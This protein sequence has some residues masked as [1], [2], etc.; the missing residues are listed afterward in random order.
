MLELA[1]L[2]RMMRKP[3][4]GKIGS[5]VNSNST[6]SS[7]NSIRIIKKM[8]NDYLITVKTTIDNQK[9]FARVKEELPNKIERLSE[10]F[11]ILSEI[12]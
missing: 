9:G 10:N 3:I 6:K 2:Q 11:P 7:T 8:E 12:S 4:Y 5:A 1:V